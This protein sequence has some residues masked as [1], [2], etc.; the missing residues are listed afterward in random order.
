MMKAL[1]IPV[2]PQEGLDLAALAEALKRHPVRACWFMTSFQNPMGASL[3]LEKKKALVALLAS[4]DI[5]LIEDDVYGELYF[6]NRAPLPAKAFD[7]KGLVMPTIDPQR[8]FTRVEEW[9]KKK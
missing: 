1:E 4:H 3:S 5:P 6:G 8:V 2:H 9:Y 7:R